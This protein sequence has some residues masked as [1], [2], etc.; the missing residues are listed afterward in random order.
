M[1][2]AV[3][4][5]ARRLIDERGAD[6]VLLCPNRAETKLFAKGANGVT[7]YSRLLD[8]SGP[9]WLR[10]VALPPELARTFRLFEVAG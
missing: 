9:E 3:D 4:A 7:L 8:G 1:T 10:P 2:G 6:L 5:E